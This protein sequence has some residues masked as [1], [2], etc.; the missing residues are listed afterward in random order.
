MDPL[1]NALENDDNILNV[2]NL[3]TEDLKDAR[4]TIYAYQSAGHSAFNFRT[5]D[6]NGRFSAM[7]ASYWQNNEISFKTDYNLRSRKNE[8]S[9]QIVKIEND[10]NFGNGADFQT[11]L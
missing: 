2:I 8:K 10:G 9:D 6:Q 3:E 5:S 11:E 4:R 1:Q 7:V